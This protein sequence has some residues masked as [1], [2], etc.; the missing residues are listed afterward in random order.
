MG[1]TA[2]LVGSGQAPP[3]AASLAAAAGLPSPASVMALSLEQLAQHLAGSGGR[4][5]GRDMEEEEDLFLVHP[6]PPQ[7]SS[8][9][10]TGAVRG[11]RGG[12]GMVHRKLNALPKF[13]PSMSKGILFWAISDLAIALYLLGGGGCLN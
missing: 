6:P 10:S 1:T 5:R 7:H 3:A 12:G 13:F 9:V 4:K 2:P 8:G 11:S